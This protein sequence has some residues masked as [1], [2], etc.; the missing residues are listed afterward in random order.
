MIRENSSW[1]SKTFFATEPVTFVTGFLFLSGRR[2]P[3][4]MVDRIEKL[5]KEISLKAV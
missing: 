4:N 5:Q 3:E 2:E 1:P